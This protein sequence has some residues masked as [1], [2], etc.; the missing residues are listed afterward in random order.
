[1]MINKDAAS[2]S[3]FENDKGIN[4]IEIID[5]IRTSA[6]LADSIRK[7]YIPRA[8]IKREP[9]AILSWAIPTANR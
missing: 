1:M 8:M 2:D 3:S 9:G 7:F 4:V 5:Y 6:F